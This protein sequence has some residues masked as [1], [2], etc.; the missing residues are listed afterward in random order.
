MLHCWKIPGGEVIPL[1]RDLADY[2]VTQASRASPRVIAERWGSHWWE[3][4]DE[5]G[6]MASRIVMELPSGSQIASL[7]PRPQHD[8]SSPGFDER[9]FKCALSPTGGL[10]AEGGDGDLTLDR[11]P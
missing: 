2:R 6:Y 7:K 11:L 3:L 10:L 4:F 9:Y 8:A 1:A 5:I